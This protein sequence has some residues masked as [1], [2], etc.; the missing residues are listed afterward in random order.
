MTT[1][2]YWPGTNI[3]KSNGNAFD[4]KNFPGLGPR[5]VT[6]RPPTLTTSLQKQRQF[7]I[8]SRAKPADAHGKSA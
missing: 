6:L 7:T 3:P 5:G 4:W 8:Y 2:I 1:S